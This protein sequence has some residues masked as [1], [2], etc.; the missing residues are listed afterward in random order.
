MSSFDPL[1]IWLAAQGTTRMIGIESDY[2]AKQ[3]DL[4]PSRDHPGRANLSQK[5]IVYPHYRR[6][7]PGREI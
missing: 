7:Q 6:T 5:S 3:V 1:A 4:A 2:P